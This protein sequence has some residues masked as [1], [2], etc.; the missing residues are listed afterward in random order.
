MEKQK[1]LLRRLKARYGRRRR[2]DEARILNRQFKEDPRHVYAIM[3][4][5][6]AQDE[7]N[8]RSR[9][10]NVNSTSQTAE[11]GDGFENIEEASGFWRAL[12]Q[13]TET[14]NECPDWLK[15]VERAFRQRVPSPKE[16]K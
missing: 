1:S 7:K 11:R 13:K 8:E 15:E 2:Q 6:V 14:E 12:W 10:K 9:Y 4:Q 16:A 3:S 5:M